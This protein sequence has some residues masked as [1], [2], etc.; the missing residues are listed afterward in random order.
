LEPKF[1][2]G[3]L[4]VVPLYFKENRYD[5]WVKQFELSNKLSGYGDLLALSLLGAA[6]GFVGEIIKAK[7]VLEIMKKIRGKQNMGNLQFG[8][9]HA[10]MGE[11]EQAFDYFDKA[12]ELHEGFALYMKA[13]CRDYASEIMK[14]PRFRKLIE[15]IGIPMDQE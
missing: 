11:F 8:V 9:F 1:H 15:R 3:Y 10:A 7:E 12:V 5:E 6:Y 4:Q 13:F 2:G 14:D